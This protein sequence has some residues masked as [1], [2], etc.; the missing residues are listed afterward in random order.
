MTGTAGDNGTADNAG[1][2]ENAG[3][4]ENRRGATAIL[5]AMDGEIAEFLQSM[6]QTSTEGWRGFRF[7]YGE[8]D[9]ERVVVAKAGVGKSLSA[10]VSQ[11]LIERFA[12]ARLIFTGLAGAVDQSLDVGD[13]MVARDCV[14]YDIDASPI[15]FEVGEIPFTPYRFLPCDRELVRAAAAVSPESGR[16]VTG[17]IG[18]GDRFLTKRDEEL[19]RWLRETLEVTA[20]EMEGASVGLAA[21][22]NDIPFLLLRTISDRADG[23]APK[24]FSAFLTRASRNSLAFVRGLLA[25]T[26]S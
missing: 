3:T 6:T 23:A 22:V 2:G 17:R 13:M 10:L 1:T 8:I 25:H 11:H 5:G 24:D 26:A 9:Q 12:P 21:A 4:E 18:T 14:Q 20:C 16:V 15:G 19:V 7:H